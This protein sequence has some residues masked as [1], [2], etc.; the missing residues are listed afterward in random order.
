MSKRESLWLKKQVFIWILCS[1]WC[2]EFMLFMMLGIPTGGFL[3]YSFCRLQLLFTSFNAIYGIIFTELW[4]AF[5]HKHKLHDN[6]GTIRYL[7]S[8][9]PVTEYSRYFYSS[10]LS[11]HLISELWLIG[12][13]CSTVIFYAFHFV[14]RQILEYYQV[15]FL[16]L[17]LKRA[18]YYESFYLLGFTNNVLLGFMAL[19]FDSARVSNC[20]ATSRLIPFYHVLQK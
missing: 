1:L 2:S 9:D 17:C 3:R 19:R 11:L 6:I 16:A 18:L 12:T 13:L 10:W 8:R 14:V 5:L 15:S 20:C 7:A 4:K